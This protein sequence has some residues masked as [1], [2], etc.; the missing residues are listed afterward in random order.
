MSKHHS[1][2]CP[3]CH[4][5]YIPNDDLRQKTKH[6]KL[7]KKFFK[8]I[9]GLIEICRG[10]HN[11]LHKLIPQDILLEKFEYE[12]ILLNFLESYKQVA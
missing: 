6:H 3:K 2:F 8:G 4:Q 7:P 11:E 9:G 12:V 5:K 10:C 1:D